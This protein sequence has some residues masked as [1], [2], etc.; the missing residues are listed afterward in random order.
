M[1]A[2][3]FNNSLA[4]VKVMFCGRDTNILIHY[5]AE[6]KPEKTRL[7]NSENSLSDIGFK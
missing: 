7:V 2:V 6:P 5:R 3:C 4:V 1:T